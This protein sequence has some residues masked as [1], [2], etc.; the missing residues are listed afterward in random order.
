M[1]RVQYK[2]T[3]KSHDNKAAPE[4]GYHITTEAQEHN[5]KSSLIKM[6]EAFHG[7]MNTSLEEMQ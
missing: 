2:N 6:T 1:A 4:P 3:I 7:E 5:L